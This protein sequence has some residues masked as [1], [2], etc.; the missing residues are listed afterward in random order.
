MDLLTAGKGMVFLH[1]AIAGWPLWPEYGEVIGDAFFICPPNAAANRCSIRA[2]GTMCPI[3]C[4][5]ST[6]DT[7]RYR[8]PR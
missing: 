2:T 7:P 6:H 3:P 5:W 8:G 4:S 1:H